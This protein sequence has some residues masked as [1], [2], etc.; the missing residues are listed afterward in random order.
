LKAI[1]EAS[2]IYLLTAR[3]VPPYHLR[4]T[5][6]TA[7]HFIFFA[8]FIVSTSYGES[9]LKKCNIP[10]KDSRQSFDSCASGDGDQIKFESKYF[11]KIAFGKNG[12]ADVS[13][14]ADCYW[15]NNKSQARKTF[16]FDNASDYFSEGFARYIDARGKFG[17]VD[18]NLKIV[19]QPRYDFVFPF[20]KGQ[21]SFCN[22]C[23]ESRG[24]GDEHAVMSG[25][26][27]GKIDKSGKIVSE[28]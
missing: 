24:A 21:A 10:T 15:V 26:T 17:F 2:T 23:K 6:F 16:C 9:A 27:W 8:M 1:R 25:G 7:L 14:G 28:H 22:G 18:S 3:K 4:M 20:E 5:N 13:V 19:V 11:S 12:L